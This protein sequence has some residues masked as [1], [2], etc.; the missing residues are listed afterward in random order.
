MFV[1]ISELKKLMKAA[2]KNGSLIIGNV[3]LNGDEGLIIAGG[4]WAFGIEYDHAPKELK[5]AVME[6]GGE[7]PYDG[8]CYRALSEGNQVHIGFTDHTNPATLFKNCTYDLTITKVVIQFLNNVRLLQNEADGHI[9]GINND[10]L[11]LIDLKSIDYDAGEYEPLGPKTSA[12]NVVCWGNNICYLAVWPYKLLDEEKDT[13]QKMFI[14]ELEQ[15][16]L[17]S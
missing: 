17:L 6:L 15:I 16:S 1:K 4:Y 13:E 14:K 8:Q 5:A 9:I 10:I 2:Y 12:H 7:I 3:P 11:K